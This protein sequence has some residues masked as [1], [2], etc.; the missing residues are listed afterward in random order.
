M[1]ILG[2]PH[3]FVDFQRTDGQGHLLLDT[4]GTRDDLARHNIDLRDGLEMLVYED[5]ADDAGNPDPLVAR[6]IVRF[7]PIQRR[8]VAHVNWTQI[9]SLSEVAPRAGPSEGG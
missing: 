9:R 1:E 8:F 7:D 4:P 5:D 3:V 6:S 2:K